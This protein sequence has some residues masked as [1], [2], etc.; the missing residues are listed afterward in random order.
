M[1]KANPNDASQ[2]VRIPV[3]GVSYFADAIKKLKAQNPNNAVVSAGD[4]VVLPHSLLRY[5]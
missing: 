3:G 2:T 5:F 4:L 1:L